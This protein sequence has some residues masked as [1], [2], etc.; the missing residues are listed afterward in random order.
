[1]K[2]AVVAMKS[3]RGAGK[4][5]RI[6]VITAATV[7]VIVVRA[8]GIRTL[9]PSSTGSLKNIRTMTRI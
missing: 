6:K 9:V 8:D 1:M 2:N 7:I 3:I 4:I 5:P